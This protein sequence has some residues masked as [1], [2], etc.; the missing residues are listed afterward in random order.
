M[1]DSHVM[2]TKCGDVGQSHKKTTIFV[3]FAIYG[4]V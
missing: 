3:D 4:T 2:V 1:Q